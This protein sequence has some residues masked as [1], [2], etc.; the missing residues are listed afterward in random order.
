ME[1]EKSRFWQTQPV[2]HNR[3]T[4]VAESTER[5]L[6]TSPVSLPAGLKWV[7]LDPTTD[8]HL[9]RLVGLL[10]EHYLVDENKNFRLLYPK[11]LLRWVLTSPGAENDFLFGLE[12][13]EGRLVGSIALLPGLLQSESDTLPVVDIDF[14]CLHEDWRLRGLAPVLIRE[15]TRRANT[16]SIFQAV[17]TN[18]KSTSLPL[19][20]VFVKHFV[21]RP[22]KLLVAHFV[23]SALAEFFHEKQLPARIEASKLRRAAPTDLPA[24]QEI[25]AALD[26]TYKKV[27]AHPKHWLLDK[28]GVV[29]SFV[30]EENRAVC[31]FVSFYEL[32]TVSLKTRTS[33]RTAVLFHLVVSTA[34]ER[35][36]LLEA[37]VVMQALG[38]DQVLAQLAGSSETLRDLGFVAGDG[39]LQ[40]YIY[41]KNY[42]PV[43][44]EKVYYPIF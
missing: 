28:E 37:L 13:T 38:F 40:F 14:L 39:C 33:F 20:S 3:E 1:N 41:N 24:I 22:K 11:K 26:K 6:G 36:V 10:D 9:Q 5:P 4:K 34:V 32:V 17:Y 7:T 18:N 42:E 31:G 16:Y 2:V 35:E 23:S 19:T 21:F 44:N 29:R 25:L 15:A 8:E 27:Y 12:D 43:S 30:F